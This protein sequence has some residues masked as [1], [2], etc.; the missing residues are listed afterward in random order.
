MKYF[1]FL[2]I[3]LVTLVAACSWGNSPKSKPAITKDT[4]LYQYKTFKQRA[5]DCG[6]KPDSGCTVVQFKYPVFKG[7]AAL[8]DTIRHRAAAL[9]DVYKATD[10]SFKQF[11]N[12]FMKA[13]QQE[14]A[15]LNKK[16]LY[17]LQTSVV[18]ARQDSAMITLQFSGYSFRGGAHGSS[19]ITFTNWDTKAHKD[20]QLKDILVDNYQPKLDSMGERIFRA[21]EKISD[22]EPLKTNYFFAKDKFA[23]NNNFMITPMGLR[24]I[25]NEYEIKPYAAGKTELFIP[26]AQIESLLRPATVV[27][28]F[29]K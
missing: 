7:D 10:T 15:G 6:T 18:V 19:L 14:N 1:L 13:Y 5:S 26:Y 29:H 2:L 9:F 3:C 8:N 16:W 11:A 25:Y 21:E 27:S 12:R 24:F 17:T 22:T 28:Q 23:L 20:I 4:L